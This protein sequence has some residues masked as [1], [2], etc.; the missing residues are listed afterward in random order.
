MDKALIA[1]MRTVVGFLLSWIKEFIQSRP[2]LKIELKTGKLNYIRQEENDMGD[3]IEKKVGPE[4]ANS[5][6]L[7]LKFDIFNIGKIGTGITDISIKLSANYQ[8]LYYHPHVSLPID[9]KKLDNVSFNL[10]SNRVYTVETFLLIDNKAPS[11]F[12]FH[13]VSLEPGKRN[14]LKIEVIVSALNKKKLSLVVEPI[15]ILTA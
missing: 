3:S 9:N 7:N 1:L 11:C 14:S 12:V 13:E 4:N 2:R 10:E 8:K 15:S 5:F 6:H